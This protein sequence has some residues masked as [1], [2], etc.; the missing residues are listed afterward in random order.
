MFS[1][2]QGMKWT[3]LPIAG[4]LYNQDPDLLDKFNAI[5]HEISEHE[6]RERAKEKAETKRAESKSKMSNGRMR[7]R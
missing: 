4:G 6:A 2:C 5:F 1:I 3:H 7:R